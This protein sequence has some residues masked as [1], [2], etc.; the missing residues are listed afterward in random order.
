MNRDVWDAEHVCQSCNKKMVKTKV[1][2]EGMPV[3]AWECKKCNETVLHPEDAQKMLVINKFKK[4]VPVRVGQLGEA[5][6][7]RFPKEFAE[8]YKIEK[9]RDL[10]LRADGESTFEVSVEP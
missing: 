9:G 4:G 10:M 2:I 5:L 3:R 8:L 1:T 6:M 7:I